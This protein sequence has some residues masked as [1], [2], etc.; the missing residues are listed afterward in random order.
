[1]AGKRSVTPH[2]A[3]AWVGRV[4]CGASLG[5]DVAITTAYTFLIGGW[6]FL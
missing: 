6:Q 4:H 1:M 5:G 3:C 2:R